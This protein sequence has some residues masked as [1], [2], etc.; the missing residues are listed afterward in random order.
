[1]ITIN[2]ESC[3]YQS[4]YLRASPCLPELYFSH[5]CPVNFSRNSIY[6]QALKTRQDRRSR[7]R[8]SRSLTFSTAAQRTWATR[9]SHSS[10][11]RP[12]YPSSRSPCSPPRCSSVY[13][14]VASSRRPSTDRVLIF[15]LLFILS[16]PHVNEHNR[17]NE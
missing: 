10:R 13:L 6:S 9:W 4:D 17:T 12:R 7:L 16:Q 2:L 11:A 3:W 1:M 14:P 8:L 15:L 5:F